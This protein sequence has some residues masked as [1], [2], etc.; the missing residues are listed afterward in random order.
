MES[1]KWKGTCVC[2]GGRVPSLN[3][4]VWRH[5]ASNRWAKQGVG[6]ICSLRVTPWKD[7]LMAYALYMLIL[8]GEAL[9]VCSNI[10]RIIFSLLLC[11]FLGSP[12]GP[13]AVR[14]KV[15]RTP[16][17]AA[18]YLT[19]GRPQLVFT[20]RMTTVRL[21]IIGTGGRDKPLRP[22]VLEAGG[23]RERVLKRWKV[24][25]YPI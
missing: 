9:W 17:A 24:F 20:V 8:L 3:T 5:L 4:G 18:C 16:W 1:L 22:S 2:F 13:P 23:C 19:T 12:I 11:S 6:G 7:D 21:W 10:I 15:A 25:L 14:E